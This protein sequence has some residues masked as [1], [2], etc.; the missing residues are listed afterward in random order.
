MPTL[1][2]IAPTKAERAL[3]I[4]GTRSGKS[5]LMDHFMRHMVR[6]RPNVQILLLD[7]KPRFRAEIERF[8]PG[9]RFAR[10]AER[11]YRDWE[12]GPVIPASI[13]VDIHAEKPLLN[14]WKDDKYERYRIAVA[15]TEQTI[16]RGRLLEIAD[17]WYTVR[18]RKSDR[19]L[20]VD[21]LLDYYHR[22]T[23]SVHSAR[24]VPLKVVRAGGERGFGALYGA[25]RPK[26]AATADYR[27]TVRSI[28]LSPPLCRRYQ[29]SVGHGYAYLH[30]TAGGGRG[31]LC[32]SYHPNPA[33]RQ[34]RIR[35]DLPPY[36]VR[37]L[38]F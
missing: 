31:R 25:Q 19:V 16:E 12:S 27:G 32:V 3:I 20:A 23:I 29:I 30:R 22:N 26:R 10:L 17:Q 35:Q 21:E 4:G 2:D 1:D 36:P 38:S 6:E 13:R 33:G 18:Q 14:F 5:T 11:H 9:N 37:Y 34:V 24:D 7:S 15:Q 8:G 28:P